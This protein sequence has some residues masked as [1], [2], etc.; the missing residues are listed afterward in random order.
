[1]AALTHARSAR[2]SGSRTTAGRIDG[3]GIRD[4]VGCEAVAIPW[5]T[6]TKLIAGRTV[7]SLDGMWWVTGVWYLL[8][9]FS[10]DLLTSATR[11][12]SQGHQGT[13]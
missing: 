3:C 12:V 1:M 10:A 4:A 9:S 11:L 7:V 8:H 2:S 5:L 13:A 6:C